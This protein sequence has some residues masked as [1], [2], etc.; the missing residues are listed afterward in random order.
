MTDKS[1]T[2]F[3][4]RPRVLVIAML[5]ILILVAAGVGAWLLMSPH[6]GRVPLVTLSEESTSTV[7]LAGAFPAEDDAPLNN[8]LGIAWDGER[9]Y[10]AEADAGAVRIFD[11]AG[12]R[13]GSIV[14]P[15]AKGIGSAYPSV[16]AVAGD[17]LAVVDNAASRVVIVAMD[18]ADPAKVLLT[19]GSG[20]KAPIQPT[21]VTYSG[22]EY[23]VADAGDQSVKVYDEA[24]VHIRTLG[25]TLEPRLGFVGGLAYVGTELVVSDSNA[26]RVVVIDPHTGEQKSLYRDRF[27]LPRALVAVDDGVVAVVDTFEGAIYFTGSDGVRRDVIDAATVPDGAPR[28]PRGASWIADD[29]RLYVT[30]ATAGRVFVYNVRLE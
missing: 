28:S 15:P 30:D 10:V 8:P 19:L 20:R 9:L 29:A 27:T 14:I 6:P 18:A 5:V 1:K 4:V 25:T 26:G 21:A 2:R 3:A 17:R 11:S 16:L 23:F 12:G 22:G 7:G 24:G 13:I